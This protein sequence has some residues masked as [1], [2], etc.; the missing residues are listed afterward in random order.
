MEKKR[1]EGR[2]MHVPA[3]PDG[4]YPP[5]SDGNAA[6]TPTATEGGGNQ[7]LPQ[8]VPTQSIARLGN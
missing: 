7:P 6:A 8:P 2:D 3:Q 4:N 5:M 1:A